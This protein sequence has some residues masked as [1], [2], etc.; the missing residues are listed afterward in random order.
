[1]ESRVSTGFAAAAEVVAVF[2]IDDPADAVLVGRA[3]S[4][5]TASSRSE[6]FTTHGPFF[7]S[8]P[9]LLAKA[10]PAAIEFG[11]HAIPDAEPTDGR[12]PG[13]LPRPCRRARRAGSM[14]RSTGARTCR[15]ALPEILAEAERSLL[16][17]RTGVLLLTVQLV[18]LAA[19]AVLL[20]ASL[21]VEHR[22]VET[23]M[24]R[25]RGAGRAR[26]VGLALIEGL[27]L[28]V[29]AALVGPWLAAAALRAFNLGGPLAEIGLAIEP[30]VTTDAYLA[31]RGRRRGL[32]HRADRARVPDG[33]LVRGGP[34]Q[35]GARR[36]G[37]DRPAPR[38]RPGAGRGRRDRPVAAPPLRRAADAIGAGHARARSAARRDAG[39]R[40]AGRGDRRAPDRAAPGPARRARRGRRPRPR[41][42]ARV[43]TARPTPAALHE[44]GAAADAGDGDGRLRRLVHVDVV[45]LAA[46]PGDLPDRRRSPGPARHAGRVDAALGA[47]PGARR[48]PGRDRAPAGRS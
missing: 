4:S 10:A 28:T 29:P 19:Y 37:R 31:G 42:V 23:A 25:S 14:R 20:S 17:S 15:P 12:R 40:A 13:R 36:D 9:D 41:P 30:E 6:R 46:R 16:V 1:M 32:P 8:E 3:S 5:G 7:T 43:A 45:G 44:G 26:I 21:L 35:G 22:R 11:W 27:F 39:D 48:R 38:P 33:T 18:V 47:R 34:R 2:R 24:L